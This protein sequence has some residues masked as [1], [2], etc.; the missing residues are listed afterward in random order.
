MKFL[1]VSEAVLRPFLVC[2][3]F[4][5][6][7]SLALVPGSVNGPVEVHCTTVFALQN[8]KFSLR[9]GS[10][11]SPYPSLSLVLECNSRIPCYKFL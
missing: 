9:L 1:E 8:G 11:S 4:F 3:L 7:S 6:D 5:S 10:Y 2:D